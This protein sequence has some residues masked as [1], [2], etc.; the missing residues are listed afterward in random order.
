MRWDDL[1][2]V[3]FDAPR[4]GPRVLGTTEVKRIDMGIHSPVRVLAEYAGPIHPGDLMRVDIPQWVGEAR[5]VEMETDYTVPGHPTTVLR[6]EEE[7]RF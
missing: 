2:R 3:T 1:P 5:V 7:S 4:S 6:L